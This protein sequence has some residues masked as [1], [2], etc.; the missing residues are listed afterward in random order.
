MSTPEHAGAG[1]RTSAK[2]LNL[3]DLLRLRT[4]ARAAGQRLVQCHG[5]FDIVHPGHIRHLRSARALGDILLVTIT[6]DSAI[7][8]GTGRPLIPQELRAENL[9][10]LD[11]VDWVYIE[12][13][14]TAIDLLERV[15]PDIYVKGK[16]Y[17]SN[18]DPRFHAERQTVE[19]HGG[20]VVF[21]SG[22][23]VF[24]SSALIAALEHTSDPFHKRL[25]QLAEQQELST[26]ALHG[27]LQAMRGKR[28]VVVGETIIDTY[29]LCDR[30][31]V[32]GE[33]PVLTLRPLEHRQY[34]GGAAVVARHAAALGARPVLV[35]ALPQTAAAEA[36]RTR[37][38][39]AGV[40]VRAVP[41]GA[42]LAEK[43]RFLV[44]AQ[45]LMK[46]DLI[47][48]LAPD[49][50]QLDALVGLA[51][52]A[53][54]ER[55]GCDAAI[56]TDFGLGLLTPAVLP[57]L[58][59]ALRPSAG[60]LAGDVSGRAA[61]LLAMREMDVL[62]PSENELRGALHLHGE[63][64]PLVVWKLLEQTSSAAAIISMGA[65]GLIAFDRL[66][67]VPAQ[68]GYA[69]RLRGEHVPALCPIAIDPL[70]C[71]DAL[72]TAATLALA[73]GASLLSAAFLGA[74]AAAIEV[75][76]LGN[77]PVSATDIRQTIA[78]L[79]GASLSYQSS[80]VAEAQPARRAS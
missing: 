22:Q 76:R 3:A 7:A 18:D 72:L 19:R 11:C 75:Q 21:S 6:G 14:P 26:P 37:L 8:K 67:G 80:E 66:A 69:T 74:C 61:G 23:V 4:A 41:V 10:E 48:P 29:V 56:I 35:T 55:S 36:L 5:C 43:Q 60:V 58:C 71:G 31:E 54:C 65:D 15:R 78:R 68:P 33:S 59:A 24:S 53:A 64:L 2:I 30:P 50:A 12:A 52:D 1:S 27:T 40:D 79:H 38:T 13:A 9:A 42:E 49:A 62:C 32:A 57:R 25:T 77:I 44:G 73:S 70:G 51:H 45:K 39:A 20:R 63:G 17:E 28:V 34:D 16:E 46:L 47:D